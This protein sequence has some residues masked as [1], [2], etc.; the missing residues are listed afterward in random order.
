[1]KQTYICQHHAQQQNPWSK[2]TL[3]ALIVFCVLVCI[4][5]IIN[6]ICVFLNLPQVA[7]S[8]ICEHLKGQ[9]DHILC[10]LIAGEFLFLVEITAFCIFLFYFVI[11][12]KFLYNFITTTALNPYAI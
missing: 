10:N 12:C 8:Q 3:P 11:G 4:F 6:F 7:H 1:M 5:S 2:C 9:S